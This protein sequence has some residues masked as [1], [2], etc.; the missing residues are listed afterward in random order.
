M[1][2]QTPETTSPSAP[3]RDAAAIAGELR[4]L[5][6]EAARSFAPANLKRAAE[7]M[8]DFADAAVRELQAQ[9]A[10]ISH[11][12]ECSEAAEEEIAALRAEG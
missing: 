9:A 12:R 11:L 1:D 3:A 6:T 7:L 4:A 10:E 5:H 8:A 2:R